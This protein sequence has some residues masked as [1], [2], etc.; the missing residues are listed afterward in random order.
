MPAGA[1]GAHWERELAADFEA[2]GYEV[3]RSS[4][5][6]G[7]YDLIVWTCHNEDQDDL[8]FIQVKRVANRKRDLSS[9]R[10]KARKGVEGRRPPYGASE[11]WVRLT[12]SW[13]VEVL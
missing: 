2:K 10:S 1:V 11:L 5:S 7:P 3:V 13:H 9:A 12:G 8:R 6:A 4:A